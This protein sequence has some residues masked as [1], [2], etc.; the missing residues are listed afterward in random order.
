VSLRLRQAIPLVALAIAFVVTGVHRYRDAGA[1]ASADPPGRAPKPFP[2]QLVAAAPALPQYADG[3]R[4]R[5]RQQAASANAMWAGVFKASGATYEAPTVA[6]GVPSNCRPNG[7]WAGLYCGEDSVIVID[8]EAHLSRHAAVGGGLSDI[9]L[10]Y[11]VAHEIGHHVQQL[12]GATPPDDIEGAQRIE[13]HAD[14]LAGVWGKAA[15]LPLPPMWIYGSDAEHGTPQ[16]RVQALNIGY[17]GGRP[18]DCDALWA[19]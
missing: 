7:G 2:A 8:V 14:C 13:L 6:D 19:G 11:I 18:A 5:I 1:S 4:T 3:P 16:E 10:G 15:G 12:R 9:A 17:R